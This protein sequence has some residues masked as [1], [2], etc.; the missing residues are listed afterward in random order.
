[1]KKEDYFKYYIQGSDH[2]LVPKDVFEELFEEMSNWREESKQLKEELK[3]LKQPTIFIDTEDM[4]ER[5]GEE[6]YKEYLKKENQQLKEKYL[7]AVADYEFGH[8]KNQKSIEYI[9]NDLQ[10]F[11]YSVEYK[12]LLEILKGEKNNG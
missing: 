7:N 11:L 12:T 4:E 2:Y 10:S 6:L 3:K 8:Y 1:M 9:E 5:Y